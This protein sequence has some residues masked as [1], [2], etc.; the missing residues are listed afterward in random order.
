MS[1][2][3]HFFDFAQGPV[4]GRRAEVVENSQ[5]RVE[6]KGTVQECLSYEAQQP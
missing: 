4:N 5:Y 6:K 2:Q 3:C 1:P